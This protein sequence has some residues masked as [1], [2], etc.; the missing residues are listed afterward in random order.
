MLDKLKS[1]I[2][3]WELF[4]KLEEY[5]PQ[6]LDQY[7]RFP[8]YLSK[9]RCVLEPQVSAFLVENGLKVNYPDNKKFAVCL[10]H[11]I[12]DVNF[13]IVS[14]SKKVIKTLSQ[15][16]LGKS[17][18][19]AMS[20]FINLLL[21]TVDKKRNPARNLTRIMD[22]ENK[23]GAKSSFYF[24]LSDETTRFGGCKIERLKKDLK[25]IVDAGWE[26]GLHGGF[27]AYIDLDEMKKTKK[28]LE[29]VIGKEVI[30]YR[31]H[32]LLFKVPTTWELLKEAGFKY[33]TT[34]GYADCVGFRN[35][36]C[37]P[38]QPFNLKTNRYIDIWEIPLNIMDTTFD[39]YMK[40]D[41]QTSWEITKRLIDTVERYKGVITIL[42]HNI[43]MFGEMGEFYEKILRYCHEKNA[44][45]TSA[46]EIYEYSGRK[47]LEQ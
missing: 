26:V 11:D 28:R 2:E 1:N 7:Q 6:L 39:T 36:M 45:M 15:H 40:F 38:F 4:T 25:T 3:L 31:N 37:H 27:K 5:E 12:D 19:E 30:G 34:F 10:T 17:M 47:A 16:Q 22:L 35:G 33:D 43:Y 8:Y 44:W 41:K 29:N 24:L 46:G 32:Y 14:I 20:S 9:H 21:S 13:P 18:A 42:W 23:Y